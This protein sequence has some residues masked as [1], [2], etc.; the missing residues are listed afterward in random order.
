MTACIGITTSLEDNTQSLRRDY[1]QA[2]EQADALPLIAPMVE[3]EDTM[4]AF[5]ERI[6]GLIITGGPA[7]T[8]G[9]IG[10]LPEELS[11]TDAVRSASDRLLLDIILDAQKPILGICY[12]MQLLNAQAGGTIYADVERQVEDA[13]VHSHKRGGSMHSLR[14]KPGTHLHRL[15]D[16]D[17][18]DIN[19]RHLQTIAEVGE[20]FRVAGTAPDGTVEAIETSDGMII[21]VQ[22]HPERMGDVMHPLFRHLVAQAQ[23]AAVPPAG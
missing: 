2:V 17:E 19:T 13:L 16:T 22:Y 9:L 1:V 3:S 6:D 21:G 12:G 20:G 23:R 5:A 11:V 8:D 14:I 18:I 10:T 15:L 7:I 4:R